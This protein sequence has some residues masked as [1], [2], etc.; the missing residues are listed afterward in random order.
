MADVPN[1]PV[2]QSD[3]SEQNF[4]EKLRCDAFAAGKTVVEMALM[5]FYALQSPVP[6]AWAKAIIIGALAYFIMPLDAIPDAIPVA[7]YSDD[8]GA[9]SAALAMVAMDITED[10]NTQARSKMEEWFGKQNSDGGSGDQSSLVR[11]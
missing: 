1:A 3:Y 6:P 10:V 11:S 2:P 8:L 4:W 9:L 7:G 5:L